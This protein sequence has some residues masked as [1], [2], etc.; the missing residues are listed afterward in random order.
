MHI[1][2]GMD[3]NPGLTPHLIRVWCRLQKF[4][5]GY[6]L[7]NFSSLAFALAQRNHKMKPLHI[8]STCSC[9]LKTSEQWRL[10][11]SVSPYSNRGF[12]RQPY[13]M[14]GQWKLFALERTFVPMGKIIYC[15][16]HPTWLPC[17]TSIVLFSPVLQTL[18]NV[19]YLFD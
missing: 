11:F 14:A 19:P 16:C 17:K 5:C 7:H 6:F 18:I 12:A 10:W 9:W 8:Y 1:K 4:W 3:W 13:W 15:S 2:P